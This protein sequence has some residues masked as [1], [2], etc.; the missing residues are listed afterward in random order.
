VQAGEGEAHR[1]PAAQ[2]GEGRDLGVGEPP[3]AL[4]AAREGRQPRGVGR[5]L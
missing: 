3:N 1:R 2:A 4:V 5:S